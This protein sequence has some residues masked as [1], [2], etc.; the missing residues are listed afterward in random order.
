MKILYGVV[1]EGMGHA[2]RSRV[3]LDHLSPDHEIM[4]VA[5]GKAEDYLKR[6]F[7]DVVEIEGLRISYEK[8]AV[9]RSATFWD[10]LTGLPGMVLHNVEK[11]VEVGLS[12]SP[13]LV[14]SDF[15]SFAYAFGL[16]HDIPVISIDNMQVI[17]RCELTVDIPEKYSNDFLLAKSIIKSKLPGCRHYLITSFFFPPL[18]KKRTSLYPPILR[19]EILEA[20]KS[21]GEHVLVYQTSSSDEELIS[22]LKQVDASFRV[23]GFRREEKIGNVQLMDFSEQG[24]IADLASCRAVVANGGFSLMGEAVFLGKPYL[25]VPVRK[26]FEQVLNSLYLQKLGYG[27]FQ[28]VI[29][30]E[31]V[32]SFLGNSERYR[33]NLKKHTQDGNRMITEALDELLASLHH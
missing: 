27:E 7:P 17:N 22:V 8:G 16:T 13:D 14:I 9:D 11:F 30:P 18:R 6:H 28:E 20:E 19:R 29:T 33:S 21:Q 26:Q 31:N 24:F 4:I 2:T 1:G 5:S 25:A 12:F 32:T 15:E 23:Y 3:I 10:L